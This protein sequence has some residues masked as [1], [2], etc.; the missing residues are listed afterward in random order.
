MH[1]YTMMKS[2]FEGKLLVQ[3]SP[4]LEN[5]Y[6]PKVV[7]GSSVWEGGANILLFACEAHAEFLG[8]RPLFQVQR[9]LVAIKGNIAVSSKEMVE[10]VHN[11]PYLRLL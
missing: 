1:A 10:N 4:T 5:T 2:Y 8:P 3:T 7:E 9:S 6:I 11:Y